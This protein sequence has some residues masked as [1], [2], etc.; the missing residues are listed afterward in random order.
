[1]TTLTK[2]TSHYRKSNVAIFCLFL[3]YLFLFSSTREKNELSKYNVYPKVEYAVISHFVDQNAPDIMLVSLLGY[4]FCLFLC[5]FLFLSSYL[6]VVNNFA[7]VVNIPIMLCVLVMV[8]SCVFFVPHVEG[9]F[10][11]S[12]SSCWSDMFFE[13]FLFSSSCKNFNLSNF[14]AFFFLFFFW[15]SEELWR[16]YSHKRS[17]QYLFLGGKNWF[18]LLRILSYLAI[19]MILVTVVVVIFCVVVVVVVVA[20]V[21]WKQISLFVDADWQIQ[22][23]TSHILSFKVVVP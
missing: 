9:V 15:N 18:G 22:W 8:E 5:L 21:V 12:S 3:F 2:K 17:T 6:A 10:P 19:F 16:K 14:Y 4:I 13:V 20:V 23:S 1:M 11:D 7:A